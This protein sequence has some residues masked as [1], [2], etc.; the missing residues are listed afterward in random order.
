MIPVVLDTNILVSALWTKTGNA[1]N[2]V[3]MFIEGRIQLYY[4]AKM[5]IE[6]KTVL[7]RPKFAFSK[8][9]T[10]ELLKSI[11]D[12]GLTVAVTPSKTAFTD[13]SDRKFY[14]V[15]KAC[16]AVLITG[17]PKHFPSDPII[18]TAAKFIEIYGIA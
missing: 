15:A 2:I 6:Y 9:N 5:M 7:I 13:E 17:N 16:G 8:V 4:D 14:D 11:R 1:A 10:E 12:E 18:I 3:R